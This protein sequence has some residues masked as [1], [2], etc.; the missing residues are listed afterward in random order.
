MHDKQTTER[1]FRRKIQLWLMELLDNEDR[2]ETLKRA[3][4]IRR[5]CELRGIYTRSSSKGRANPADFRTNRRTSH[6]PWRTS[7]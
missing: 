5:S 3:R 1:P 7:T 4:T 2:A 6:M